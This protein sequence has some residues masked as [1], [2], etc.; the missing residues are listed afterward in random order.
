MSSPYPSH[1]GR[2][3]AMAMRR[4]RCP[5][6]ENVNP[7]IPN[8]DRTDL[9]SLVCHHSKTSIALAQI[10][11]LSPLSAFH[12][13][14]SSPSHFSRAMGTAEFLLSSTSAAVCCKQDLKMPQTGRK[15]ESSGKYRS[16]ECFSPQ[17]VAF[18]HVAKSSAAK[19]FNGQLRL[20]YHY[21]PKLQGTV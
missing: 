9:I 14:S 7:D 21:G 5:I 4:C 16:A 11:N 8:Q 15:E 3:G 12:Q 10:C 13:V 20:G 17:T 18:Q 19:N 1:R 2:K 6:G